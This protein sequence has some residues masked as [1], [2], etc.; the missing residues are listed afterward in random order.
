[1]D[2]Q[3][4]AESGAE[5][6]VTP[7]RSATPP[8]CPFS[9]H[10]SIASGASRSSSKAIVE[11][12]PRPVSK[13]GSRRSRTRSP[14]SARRCARPWS[15]RLSS[16]PSPPRPRAKPS[17]PRL[18]AYAPPRQPVQRQFCCSR[19]RGAA[20]SRARRPPSSCSCSR[21]SSSC[22][23][24]TCRRS[25]CA[26]CAIAIPLPIAIWMTLRRRIQPGL[27]IAMAVAIGLIAVGGMSYVTGLH[28]HTSFLPED[29]REWRETFEYVAS[30]AFAYGTGVLISA[31]LQ[32]RSGARTAPVRSRSGSR[33]SS[34]R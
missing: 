22:S 11:P 15:P 26:W 34:S 31:A 9:G 5:P 14:R 32:A 30:I 27:E 6:P 1:M 20:P 24:S 10:S 7:D 13:G 18:W 23:C 29:R 3:S 19:N 8:T 33:R 17:P 2:E 4:K 16:R 25:C 12:S 28:E 21:T